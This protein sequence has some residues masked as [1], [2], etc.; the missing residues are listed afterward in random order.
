MLH[1]QKFE[2]GFEIASHS[3][4]SYNENMANPQRCKIFVH[5]LMCIVILCFMFIAVMFLFNDNVIL[6]FLWTQIIKDL[7]VS[8]I[9]W[10][11][12]YA[13]VVLHG[14]CMSQRGS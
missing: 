3:F 12:M 5:G 2:K 11:K 1:I 13:Y 9:L 6:M 7:R 8:N 10:T 4:A 14:F